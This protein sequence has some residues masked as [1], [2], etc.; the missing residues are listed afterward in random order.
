MSL[1]NISIALAS[2]VVLAAAP[3]FA[4]D[5][6]TSLSNIQTNQ[7]TGDRNTSRN[8]STQRSVT[9][10]RGGKTGDAATV[11]SN[12]QMNDTVGNRNNSRN[13]ND[14]RSGTVQVPN[15]K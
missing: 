15:K 2:V 5:A 4:G 1:R 3:A 12:D 7:T 14:Q 13:I 9:G 8:E 6:G 11:I 10:Q